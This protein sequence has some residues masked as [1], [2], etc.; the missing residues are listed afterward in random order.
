MP[1][2]SWLSPLIDLSSYG[3]DVTEYFNKLYSVFE[4]DFISTKATLN[5]KPIIFDNR[6][7]DQN[8]VECFWH[9]TSTDDPANGRLPDMRR[10]ERIGWVKLIINHDTDPAIL[11]WEN[12][13]DGRICTLLFLKD[14]DFLVVLG[15]R[16]KNYFLNT[17]IH[18]DYPNRKD[19]LIAE[20]EEYIKNGRKPLKT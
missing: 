12:I 18:I 11:K 16:R 5:G 20:Y 10:C 17:A 13:R 19:R 8:R 4:A 3:G 2:P 15:N 1:L 9:I 14:G 7:G 6:V